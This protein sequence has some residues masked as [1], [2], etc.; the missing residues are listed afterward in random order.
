MNGTSREPIYWSEEM[1][2]LFG[3]DP[4]EGLP[5]RDQVWQRIHPQD[6][7][8]VGEASD[9]AFLE[10]VDSDVEY[11]IVL[12]DGT[13]KFVH[14]LAHPVLSANGEIAEVVATMVD[15]TER[16]RAEEALRES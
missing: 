5:T 11:R 7:D 9:R 15:I 6:H 1:F 8:K 3:T 14:T 4:K 12:P 13:V 2:R 10:K 16:K